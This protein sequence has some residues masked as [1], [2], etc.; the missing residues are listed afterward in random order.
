MRLINPYLGLAAAWCLAAATP[1]LP[2]DTIETW[3]AGSGDIDFYLMMDGMGQDAASQGVAGDMLLGWGVA[4]RLSAYLA[5]SL[6]ADG[7]FNDSGAEMGVGLFGTPVDTDHVDLDLVLDI[8]AGVAGRREFCLGP[9]VEL[10]LDA[11]P[12]RTAWGFYARTGLAVS[13]RGESA[14]EAT[15]KVDGGA[16]T[17]PARLV[18]G[19][20]TVGGYLTL[21]PRRQLLL[22]YDVTYL[23]EPTPG[24]PAIEHGG[25]ALG[26]NQAISDRL[27]FISQA[28]FDVPQ[29]GQTSSL[30][31]MVGFIASLPG[32]GGGMGG[33]LP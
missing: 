17:G 1:V 26:Y 32:G 20:L 10:N 19:L 27:E 12:E 4:D 31:M 14:P 24:E 33:V 22:E 9:T 25:L 3:D 7:Y 15:A 11:A 13:G 6:M 2:A 16:I 18:D 28:R 23:D 5:V 8:C 21:D 29:G 30:S